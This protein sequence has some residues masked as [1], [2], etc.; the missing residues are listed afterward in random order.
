MSK[1]EENPEDFIRL[2]GSEVVND[3]RFKTSRH[4]TKFEVKKIEKSKNPEKVLRRCIELS[5][6]GGMHEC[7]KAIGFP[8]KFGIRLFSPMLK[9]DMWFAIGKLNPNTIDSMLNRFHQVDISAEPCSI[10]GAPFTVEVTTVCEE[11]LWRLY[12]HQKRSMPGSGRKR[13]RKS[14]DNDIQYAYH[15]DGLIKINNLNDNF[16]L[17]HAC[18]MARMDKVTRNRD[19]FRRYKE[20]YA[21]QLE[22]VQALM[23]SIGAPDNLTSYDAEDWL[24]RVQDYYDQQYP[25][26]F[27][28]YVFQ[29][30]GKY[31]PKMKTG[32]IHNLHPLCL[33]YD[34]E[35]YDT[36]PKI[37]RFFA[38]VQNYCFACESPFQDLNKHRI[39]C[40]LLCIMC[41]GNFST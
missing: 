36:I 31:K 27:S 19:R 3:P 30:Y 6:E 25:G 20:S 17:F 4:R 12:G 1:Q 2:V 13:L 18:E 28:I 21:H 29:K 7:K 24:Q 11:E 39:K 32:N 15:D 14:E 37:N 22:N 9:Y 10:L 38:S 40:A 16:C 8:D 5:I 26:Q 23:E 33:Y 35:H 41:R 34:D